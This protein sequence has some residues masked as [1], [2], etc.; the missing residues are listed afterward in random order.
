M[1]EYKFGGGGGGRWGG[2]RKSNGV[3]EFADG[4]NSPRCHSGENPE[5]MQ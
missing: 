1:D 5:H 3:D 2:A 4:G